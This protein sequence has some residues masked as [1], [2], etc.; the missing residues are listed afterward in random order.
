MTH[1]NVV[2][3]LSQRCANSDNYAKLHKKYIKL[4]KKMYLQR[5]LNVGT[6]L[7][8]LAAEPEIFQ[9][10]HNDFPT[11]TLSP[12]GLCATLWNYCGNVEPTL[13]QRCLIIDYSG[14]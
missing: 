13:P 1:A 5:W 6:A 7:A 2:P 12:F 9:R 10:F 11:L 3:T 14:C 8:I 4:N